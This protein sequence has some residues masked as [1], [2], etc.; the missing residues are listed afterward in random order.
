MG[1][2]PYYV[3]AVSL[4]RMLDRPFVVSGLGILFGYLQALLRRQPRFEGPPG[5]RRFFRGFERSCL[6]RGKRQTITR[7][8]ERIRADFPP[9]AERQVVSAGVAGPRLGGA[10]PLDRSGGET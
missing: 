4:Y 9:P 10:I 1:S 2:A 7:Y 8:H 5:Y 3:L 6:L